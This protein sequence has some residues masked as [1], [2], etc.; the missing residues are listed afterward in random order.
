MRFKAQAQSE[1]QPLNNNTNA[2]HLESAQLLHHTAPCK[3]MSEFDEALLDR[4]IADPSLLPV[5][6]EACRIVYNHTI[7]AST[8][9]AMLSSGCIV[10]GLKGDPFHCPPADSGTN[11]P[12]CEVQEVKFSLLPYKERYKGRKENFKSKPELRKSILKKPR[13]LP[14]SL[15]RAI[16]SR[17]STPRVHFEVDL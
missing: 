8:L 7:A 5:P 14:A 13:T 10:P 4:V 1:S 11:F 6:D 12:Y 17:T 16:D 15:S 9:L 2:T 3:H